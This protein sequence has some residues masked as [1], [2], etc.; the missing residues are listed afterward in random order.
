MMIKKLLL[1]SLIFF[2][3][4]P[5]FS[6]T[7]FVNYKTEKIIIEE[8]II[9]ERKIKSSDGSLISEEYKI[10]INGNY[11]SAV[12]NNGKWELSPKGKVELEKSHENKDMSSSS[13]GGCGG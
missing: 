10:L 2:Y 8:G 12:L 5:V 4:T 11:Y 9:L 6:Q 1:A 13:G 7:V 3:L